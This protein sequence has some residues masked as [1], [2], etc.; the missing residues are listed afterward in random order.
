MRK[1]IEK[2]LSFWI[3]RRLVS[4]TDL[5]VESSENNCTKITSAFNSLIKR[6]LIKFSNYILRALLA[7]P[8]QAAP[9]IS[10]TP[11]RRTNHSSVVS[12]FYMCSSIF[13]FVFILWLLLFFCYLMQILMP[14]LCV[15]CVQL[16]EDLSSKEHT[17]EYHFFEWVNR[18]RNLQTSSTKRF[19]TYILYLHNNNN[20]YTTTQ[21]KVLKTG[22]NLKFEALVCD[23]KRIS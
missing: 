7:F 5:P 8:V 6:N 3:Y 2:T 18:G 10:F 15:Y 22:K 21:W 19:I 4:L 23:S 11:F 12:F 9:L 1:T 16:C 13:S 14:I 17:Y 20:G